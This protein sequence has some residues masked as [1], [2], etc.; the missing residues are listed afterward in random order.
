MK[1]YNYLLKKKLINKK[2]IIKISNELRDIKIPAYKDIK[3]NIIFLKKNIRNTEYYKNSI[4]ILGKYSLDDYTRRYK[5]FKKLFKNKDVLDFGCGNGIFLK[6][7][8]DAKSYNGVELNLSNIN[9]IKRNIKKINIKDNIEKFDKKFDIVTLFHV[10]E[11]LDNPIVYLKKIKNKLKKKGRIIIEVPSSKDILINNKFL[12]NNFLKFTLW[13]EHLML[14]TKKTLITFLKDAGFKK[15]KVS[16]FQRY[17]LNNHLYWIL[18]NKPSGHKR[19]KLVRNKKI[20]NYYNKILV[21][22]EL[23]DTLLAEAIK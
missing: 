9:F 13:S 11:H 15:I 14:H 19:F 23:T 20:L 17:N 22:N 21:S 6:K 8:K 12:N 1:I 2:N 7:I 4:N 10:L 18:F 16:Y 3:S 5:T